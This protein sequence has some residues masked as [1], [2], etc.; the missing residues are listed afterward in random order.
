MNGSLDIKDIVIDLQVY[1][2]P[3]WSSR[4]VEHYAEALEAGERFP[5]IVLEQG[6]NR[7]LDGMH[8]YQAHLSLARESIEVEYDAV[9]EGVPTKL[10]A[11]S[12]SAKHGDRIAGAELKEVARE[13]IHD[14][15]DFNMRT[16]AQMLGVTRQTVGRWVGDITERRREVRKVKT[17][18]LSRAGWTQEDIGEFLSVPRRTVG[19]DVT[20]NI[21]ANLT[22]DLLREAS[23]GLPGE[24]DES[25]RRGSSD[26]DRRPAAGHEEDRGRR[27]RSRGEG[28]DQGGG[29]SFIDKAKEALSGEDT[30][31]REESRTNREDEPPRRRVRR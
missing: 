12:L 19:D 15:P 11:A 31:G 8:R 21:S 27:A 28:R 29:T 18:V 9:P 20:S 7:L 24:L 10:Y 30:R 1:P 17:L 6:T 13:T 4:T 3:Q 16:V 14:N 22:E 23:E 25:A 5:S 2:R 26:R